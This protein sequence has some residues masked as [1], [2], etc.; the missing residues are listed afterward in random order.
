VIEVYGDNLE[1][2]YAVLING[3][4]YGGDVDA[5]GAGNM[6]F[7]SYH[8]AAAYLLDILGLDAYLDASSGAKR[9][10]ASGVSQ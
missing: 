4:Q 9:L 2:R 5:S 3:F 6:T 1:T 7:E 8:D 10:P